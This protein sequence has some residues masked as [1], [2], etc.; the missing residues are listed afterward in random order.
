MSVHSADTTLTLLE[1]SDYYLFIEVPSP[2][3]CR[4]ELERM[5]DKKQQSLPGYHLRG[6][7]L[8]TALI[9]HGCSSSSGFEPDNV[10]NSTEFDVFTTGAENVTVVEGAGD[11]TRIALQLNR[12]DGGNTPI[13]LSATGAT[14]EDDLN[15]QVE[16]SNTTLN[17][18]NDQSELL[19][20]IGVGGLPIAEHQRTI[21]ISA[22]DGQNTDQ[23]EVNVTVQPTT[24]PDIYLLVGQSN[25]IGF[26]GDGT[27]QAGPGGPDETN[28]RIRQ[29]NVTYNDENSFFNEAS[30][31][32]NVERNVMSPAIITAEDPLHIPLGQN[33]DSKDGDFIGLGLSFAKAA[34]ENTT[35]DIVL[36]PAAWSGS[37]FCNNNQGPMGQWNADET[38]NPALGNTWLF[39]RA[40]TRTN[41]AIDETG[42]VLRGILWHQGESDANQECAAVYLENLEHMAQ[43]LRTRIK[44]DIRGEEFRHV[45]APIPFVSGTMS[46]GFDERDDLSVF[47]PDKQLIDDSHKLLPSELS[48]AGNSVHDDL[49]GPQWPCGNTTCIHFGPE[50]LRTI[51]R[52]YYEQLIGVMTAQ[53]Q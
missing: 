39:D 44:P 35:T 48:Y 4:I 34:L 6:T 17:G 42:G 12:T 49:V 30:A 14:L 32:R 1:F 5:A 52:R 27:K 7:L 21:L 41:A 53:L 33:A 9:L 38:D 16:F 28:P 29:L 25:M 2:S 46:R 10:L 8:A 24:A 26:S 3:T 36:V 45:D 40:V 13:T 15:M 18:E 19:L 51:G 11:A 22:T 50:A 31:F 37:A 23:V 43:Q 20:R 47:G